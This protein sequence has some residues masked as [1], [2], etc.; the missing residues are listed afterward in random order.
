MSERLYRH[1]R[2]TFAQQFSG[3]VRIQLF[4]RSGTQGVNVESGNLC[5]VVLTASDH[6]VVCMSWHPMVYGVCCSGVFACGVWG[7]L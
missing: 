7:V 3:Q 2:Y 1:H 5:V 4:I 6:G